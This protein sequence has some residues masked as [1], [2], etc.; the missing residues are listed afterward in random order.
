MKNSTASRVFSSTALSQSLA[1]V[2]VLGSAFT[3]AGCS[4]DKEDAAGF[5]NDAMKSSLFLTAAELE[6]KNTKVVDSDSVTSEV[7]G[8]SDI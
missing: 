7:N 3:L 4:D 2:L 5:D 6:T 8:L 1:A